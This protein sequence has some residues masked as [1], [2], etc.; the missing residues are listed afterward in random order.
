MKSPYSLQLKISFPD[1][2]HA[3][4]IFDAISPEL[5]GKHEKRAFTSMDI[6]KN[7]LSLNINASDATS[8]KASLNSY[9]KLII[10]GNNLING[11]I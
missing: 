10:L 7:V 9:M 11:G 5:H 8:L 4:I 3:K 1:I 2:K 6:N